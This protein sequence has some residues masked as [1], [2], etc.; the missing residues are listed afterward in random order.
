[1]AGV[2]GGDSTVSDLRGDGDDV[3]IEISNCVIDFI[4][5]VDDVFNDLMNDVIEFMCVVEKMD[6]GASFSMSGDASRI[7]TNLPSRI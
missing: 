3:F 6:S 7:V 5:Y 1:M 2:I 4:M